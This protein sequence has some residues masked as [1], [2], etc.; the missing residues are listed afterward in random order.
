MAFRTSGAFTSA[1][2]IRSVKLIEGTGYALKYDQPTCKTHSCRVHHHELPK[3]HRP[4]GQQAGT[5]LVDR[6]VC[7][8]AGFVGLEQE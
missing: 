5:L 2:P 7:T 8:A 4:S 3:R 6:N 1:R